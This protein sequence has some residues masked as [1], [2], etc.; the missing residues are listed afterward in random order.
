MRLEAERRRLREALEAAEARATRVEVGRRSLEGELKRF[1]LSLGD[2][3]TESQATQ[4]RHDNLLKQVA[5]GE[6]RVSQLQRE[7]DRLSQ[8]LLKAYDSESALKEKATSL[9]QSLQEVAATH[10]STQSRLA[11]LQKTSSMSEQ[12]KR[13]LQVRNKVSLTAVDNAKKR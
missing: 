7:V 8:A 1:K 6:A 3:Q 13:R 5:D 12:E 10:S 11:A 9:N 2:R 4:E